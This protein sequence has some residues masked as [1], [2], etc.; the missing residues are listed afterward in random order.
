MEETSS[1]LSDSSPKR[2]YLERSLLCLFALVCIAF[3]N[4]DVVG[5]SAYGERPNDDNPYVLIASNGPFLKEETKTFNVETNG[6][7][8][9]VASHYLDEDN[10][11][12]GR[13]NPNNIRTYIVQ[14]GDTLSEIAEAFCV[15]EHTIAWQNNIRYAS[16]IKVGGE[17]II[18]PVTGVLH[19]VKESDTIESISKKYDADVNEVKLFN[20]IKSEKDLVVGNEI[21]IPDGERNDVIVYRDGRFNRTR[22][23]GNYGPNFD[24]FF[25]AP[26]QGGEITQT[27]HGYN[28]VDFDAPYGYPIR[29]AMAGKVIV[30]KNYGWNG[31]YGKYI[32]LQHE[33]NTQTLYSHQS[34]NVVEKGQVVSQGQVIGYVGNTGKHIK[35]GGDGSHLHFEVRGAK[36]PFRNCP[37]YTVCE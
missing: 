27:L 32:V 28:A 37:L 29:A 22:V 31:G 8:V 5:D 15:S 36:N 34:R 4:N 7:L 30:V 1:Q 13:P 9:A 19:E 26:I 14:K 16:D 10:S 20:G 21:V 23:R 3:F 24:N 18:L 25:I 33:N 2:R 17:L 35:L 11:R 6:V 12:C